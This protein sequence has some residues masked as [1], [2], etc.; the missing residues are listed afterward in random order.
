MDVDG[1]GR[2]VAHAGAFLDGMVVCGS[3][4][5]GPSLPADEKRVAVEAF[6]DAAAG[7]FPIILGAAGTSLAEVISTLRMGEQLGAARI[8]VVATS[9]VREAENRRDFLDL[10]RFVDLNDCRVV[11]PRRKPGFA[12]ETL[13]LRRPRVAQVLKGDGPS[14]V[15]VP[16]Q[17]DG[18]AATASTASAT[19]ARTR[20]R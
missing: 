17:I 11:Q 7:R 9:A 19:A 15:I 2:F 1:I 20:S 8:H 12:K 3:C 18:A 5:E 16:G 14:Q 4:G 13:Q 6:L 10:A